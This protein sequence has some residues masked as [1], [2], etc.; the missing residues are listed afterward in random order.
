[1]KLKQLSAHAAIDVQLQIALSHGLASDGQQSC[2]GSETD[3]PADILFA[4]ATAVTGSTATEAAMRNANMVRAMLM[5]GVRAH[6]I[7]GCPR[8]GSSDGFASI[9][10]FLMAAQDGPSRI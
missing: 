10:Q 1:M 2:I 3:A 6:G 5:L 9:G 8:M 4:P 7:S